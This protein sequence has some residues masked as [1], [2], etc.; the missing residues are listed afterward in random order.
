MLIKLEE[1]AR[2]HPLDNKLLKVRF[3]PKSRFLA[4]AT[5]RMPCSINVSSGCTGVLRF[6]LDDK[7]WEG[8]LFS[9]L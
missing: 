2:P 5:G 6:A 1:I 8:F 9:E 7:K 4:E 3:L